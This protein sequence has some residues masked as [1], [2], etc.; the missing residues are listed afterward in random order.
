MSSCRQPLPSLCFHCHSWNTHGRVGIAL[1]NGHINIITCRPGNVIDYIKKM[2]AQAR[3]ALVDC[4]VATSQADAASCVKLFSCSL[5][6]CS[7]IRDC[8][9]DVQLNFRQ[10]AQRCCSTPSWSG[11]QLLPKAHDRPMPR[12]RTAKN[13]QNVS[14]LVTPLNR[15]GT[16]TD[17]RC[18]HDSNMRGRT[19]VITSQMDAVPVKI[20]IYVPQYRFNQAF[21]RH[22]CSQHFGTDW[23]RQS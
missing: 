10:I 17:S 5:R 6:K 15:S 23:Q 19:Q 3:A 8:L 11:M 18:R 14:F 7:C 9:Q 13:C 20:I 4:K 22:T 16:T 21:K 12:D 2:A 1:V